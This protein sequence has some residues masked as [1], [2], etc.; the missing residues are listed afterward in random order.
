MMFNAHSE[1]AIPPESRFITELYAGKNEVEVAPLLDR[2]AAHKRFRLWDLPIESVHRRLDDRTTMPYVEVMEAVYVAYARAQDKQRWG[3]KTPRYIKEMPLLAKLWPEARFI[4]II[5]DGRNV[6]LSYADVPFGPKT[7]A[8]AAALWAERVSAGINDGRALGDRY[9][10][11]KYEELVADIESHAKRL[12]DFIDAPFD[13]GMLHYTERTRDDVMPWA[14]SN[15]PNI[16]KPVMTNIRSWEEKM[17]DDQVAIFE[18]IAGDLLKRLGYPV[19]HERVGA[20]TRLA[21]TL[22]TLGLPVGRL[23]SSR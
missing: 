9:I 18:S 10:E 15:N 8:K 4:H 6:A 13:V 17:P 2:L 12:C 11:I 21:A 14:G 1:I 23:R 22:G 19:R 7:V 20:G 5:R 3:D 16:T